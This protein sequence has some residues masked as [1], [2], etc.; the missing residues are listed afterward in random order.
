MKVMIDTN[1][2]I[3]AALSPNGMSAQAF[4]KALS[5]P[6][7]LFGRQADAHTYHIPL[8]RG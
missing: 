3:S 8:I 6:Y 1:I 4:I 5:S 7:R 2:F